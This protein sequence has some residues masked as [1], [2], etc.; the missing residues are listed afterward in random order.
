MTR[1]SL[2]RIDASR[3]KYYYCAS[4]NPGEKQVE[5]S[6]EICILVLRLLD[7]NLGR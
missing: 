5:E 2:G 1:F 4:C 6:S 3:V 7:S